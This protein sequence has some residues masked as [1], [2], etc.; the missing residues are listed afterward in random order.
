MAI[1][2][3]LGESKIGGLLVGVVLLVIAGVALTIELWPT[4]QHVNLATNYYSDDDGKTYYSDSLFKFS[5]YAHEGKTAYR[6]FVYQSDHGK[7]VGFLLRYKP[8]ARKRLEDAY[9]K[10]QASGA[11]PQ[12]AVLLTIANNDIRYG[13]AEV[14]F[15]AD[16]KWRTMG[17]SFPIVKAPDGSTCYE[18]DP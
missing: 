13:G 14:R 2:E 3:K 9:N 15:P 6:A 16:T 17:M 8:Y 5:P 10:A 18:V 7:F 4:T 1:R 12:K 11:D